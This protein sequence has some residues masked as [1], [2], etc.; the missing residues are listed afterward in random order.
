MDIN[1]PANINLEQYNSSLA[2]CIK[3]VEN[4]HGTT[5]QNICDGSITFVQNG[6]MDYILKSFII[7]AL[8]LIVILCVAFVIAVI[9]DKRF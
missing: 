5:Y 1:I 3:R 6:F 7:F 2:E 8:G 9:R 4:F